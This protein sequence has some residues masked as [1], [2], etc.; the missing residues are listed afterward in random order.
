MA[1]GYFITG[2]DT[3]IGKT[4]VAT[5]LLD[6]FNRQGFRTA[7]IKP[8]ASDSKHTENGLRNEDALLLQKHAS[9]HFNYDLVNPYCIEEPIS[10]HIALARQGTPLC[11]KDLLLAC[12]PILNQAPD[13]T[14][15]E[16]VGGWTVPLNHQESMADFAIALGFPVILVVGMKL[17]C[18]N[19]TLLTYYQLQK[20][21]LQIAGWI[22]NCFDPNMRALQENI[23]TLKEKL[24]IPLI[25]VIPFQ[26]AKVDI[27]L[28]V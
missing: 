3:S 21:P 20:S 2:T 12:Q 17:G 15:V 24:P 13:I 28:I 19:H 22:A 9:S 25:S 10:P 1:K 27:D 6:H 16:G 18:L 14:L 7:A 5:K 4:Y 26:P 11:V 8:L 23:D